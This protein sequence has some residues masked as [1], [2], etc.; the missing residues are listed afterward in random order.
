MPSDFKYS[1]TRICLRTGQLTLPLSMLELF[2]ADGEVRA[3]DSG[4]GTE[5]SLTL[6]PPRNVGGL[7]EFFS[8]HDLDVNDQILIRL[9]DDGRY[10]LTA[11]PRPKKVK[12]SREEISDKLVDDLLE[13]ATPMSEAEIRSMMPAIPADF[14]LR[15]LLERDGRLVKREGRWG[16]PKTAL[17]AGEAE[18]APAQPHPGATVSEIKLEPLPPDAAA[19]AQQP[20]KKPERKA[21]KKSGWRAT[22]TPYPLSVMFPGNTGL[23]SAQEET[24][25]SSL[26][27][28]ARDA[29]QQFGFGLEGRSQGLL[30]FAELGRKKYSVLVHLHPEAAQLDWTSLMARRREAGASYLAVFGAHRDLLKLSSPADGAK[31]TLWSWE[32]LRRIEDLVRTVPFS[33]FD[34]EPHFQRDGLFEYGLERFEK[35]VARRI[36]ERGNFSAVLARLATMKAPVVF[37]LEDV[38]LDTEMS[39]DEALKVLELLAQAPFHMVA[40]VDDGEFCLRYGVASGLL[41]LS[42]YALSLRDRLPSRHTE[43]LTATADLDDTYSFDDPAEGQEQE[44][45]KVPEEVGANANGA[46]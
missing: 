4:K 15:G 38:M 10:A 29:L 2:P 13:L 37:L 35:T 28:R 16:K 32:A 27:S 20:P 14:D 45:E 7:A 11:L 1:L 33:P 18:G 6:L 43:R 8:A 40:K 39:R 41:H 3:F 46:Q 44:D 21:K 5:F 31:A 12:R 23:N 36:T 22:V 25:D 30:A 42:E 17:Q 26:H 9:H 19:S 34:L 24:A